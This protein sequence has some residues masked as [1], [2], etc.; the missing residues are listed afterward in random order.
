MKSARARAR[1]DA[2]I[3]KVERI[4]ERLSAIA[5]RVDKDIALL[6]NGR[7]VFSTELRHLTPQDVDTLGSE[8]RA[9][10]SIYDV[11]RHALAKRGTAEQ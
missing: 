5:R 10:E 9:L 7:C 11:A 6:P 1:R 2:E 4:A 3:Y 8:I